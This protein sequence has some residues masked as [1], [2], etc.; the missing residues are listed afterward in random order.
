[1][2]K[3][4]FRNLLIPVILF[5]FGFSFATPVL[6]A[7]EGAPTISAAPIVISVGGTYD[8]MAGLVV[9]D[10]IDSEADLLANLSYYDLDVDV[11]TEGD[12]IIHYDV[13]DSDDHWASFRRLVI[14]LGSDMPVIGVVTAAVYKDSTFDPYEGM[15]A[16]D[17]KDG[18]ITSSVAITYNDVTLSVPGDYFITYEVTDSD[19]NSDVRTRHIVVLWPEEY[20]PVI[21]AAKLFLKVG[22]EFMPMDGV[23]ATDQTDG[24]LTGSVIVDYAEVDTSIPGIYWTQYVVY[25]SLGLMSYAGREVIVLDMSSSPSIIAGNGYCQT[26]EPFDPK[27]GVYA[28]DLEEG[29]ITNR[30][31]IVENTVDTSR[32]GEYYVIYSVQDSD[33]N[34]AQYT[35]YVTVEW[36]WEVMPD[37]QVDPYMVFL[38]LNAAFDPMQG[39]SAIDPTDGDITDQVMLESYVD[40]SMPGLYYVEYSI[41]NSL[42]ISNGASRQVIVFESS[43]PIIMAYDFE[44][45]LNQE[46]DQS[47]THFEAYDLEDGDIWESII[48]D[49]SAVDINTAGTYPIMLSVTDSD[50]NMAEATCYVTIKDYSYPELEV[51]DYSIIIGSDYDPLNYAYAWDQKD[52]EIS[53]LVEV[54]ENNV[55]INTLGTYTVTYSVTNSQEKTTTK[56]VNV[57]VINEPV[58]DYYLIYDGNM[59]RMEMDEQAQMTYVTSPVLIPAGS[60][61]SLAQYVDGELM[62]EI[63][64]LILANEIQ[65]GFLYSLSTNDAGEIVATT[66][67]YLYDGAALRLNGKNGEIKFTST[68]DGEVYYA[69]AEKDAGVPDIDTSGEGIL[70]KTGVN[71]ITVA[72]VKPGIKPQ[73]V[74]VVIKASNDEL[75]NVLEIEI[76]AIPTP[77]NNGKKPDNPGKPTDQ[78]SVPDVVEE[79]PAVEEPRNNNGQDKKDAPVGEPVIEEPKNN[80][81]QDKKEEIPVIESAVEEP[82]TD[83][84][85]GQEKKALEVIVEEIAEEILLIPEV[86]MIEILDE[87]KDKEKDKKVE[88]P[89][90]LLEE[91]S[92]SG[93]SDKG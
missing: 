80:K 87:G 72:N 61:L 59:I 65:P 14:V 25:N 69:V 50:G 3:R 7:E 44:S 20:Y 63:P 33:G 46:I 6:A 66:S 29:D 4:K 51:Y 47:S 9:T 40:T 38:S 86:E 8:P 68:V 67:P 27:L 64:G 19:L 16:Y 48:W 23:T 92:N 58:I 78:T 49:K 56:T 76:P 24:I 39:V 85:L 10:D 53:Y 42:G 55:D 11:N 89:V 13:F 82:K 88:E 12:Y 34:S 21:T 28:Y 2:N 71:T 75:S 52:G 57:E 79:V 15:Y 83:K 30:I 84:G 43:V 5:F 62:F 74:Y 35:S 1:M 37:I 36:S 18:D 60:M 93:K 73:V 45:P 22:D 54:L 90:E 77:P 17:L 70:G 32:A 31:E 91:K 81:G 26:G 41:T